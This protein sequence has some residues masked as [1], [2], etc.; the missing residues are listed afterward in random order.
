MDKKNKIKTF[1]I[2]HKCY[3]LT[4]DDYYISYIKNTKNTYICKNIEDK[5]SLFE[6]SIF[7][8]NNNTIEYFNDYNNKIAILKLNYNNKIVTIPV[9]I[10]FNHIVDEQALLFPNRYLIW[11]IQD[12]YIYSLNGSI[13]CYSI[14]DQGECHLFFEKRTYDLKQNFVKYKHIP[15][16]KDI[17]FSP[18][19]LHFYELNKYCLL[20]TQNKEEYIGVE[21]QNKE[22][23]FTIQSECSS[24]CY[25]IIFV[26][27]EIETIKD[28]NKLI[29]LRHKYGFFANQ[30]PLLCCFNHNIE[31][32]EQVSENE[33]IRLQKE[34]KRTLKYWNFSNDE[35]ENS[36]FSID[37]FPCIYHINTNNNLTFEFIT[38]SLS[39]SNKNRVII[40]ELY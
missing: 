14:N 30:T 23:R 25:F 29:I 20:K 24:N 11:Y 27:S 13:L 36:L 37:G 16:L 12:M 2:K 7:S 8:S 22:I 26:I 10:C 28:T 17:K 4:K 5:Y 31:D 19:Y 15:Y 35:K 9:L 32:I 18:Y 1:I 3:L 21:L 40:K 34:S 38:S 6:I 33:K 39:Y